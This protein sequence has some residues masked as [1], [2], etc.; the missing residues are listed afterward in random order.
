[1]A[2]YIY[3]LMQELH[4]LGLEMVRGSLETMDQMLQESPVRRRQWG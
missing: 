4:K 2:K 3:G 1:M